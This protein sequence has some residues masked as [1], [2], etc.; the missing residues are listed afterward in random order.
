MCLEKKRKLVKSNRNIK[1]RWEL[2]VQLTKGIPDSQE[3]L[4]WNPLLK[5]TIFAKTRR[6]FIIHI[7][8]FSK[9][10]RGVHGVHGSASLM[11]ANLENQRKSGPDLSKLRTATI[12]TNVQYRNDQR[13]PRWMFGSGFTRLADPGFQTRNTPS[14]WKSVKLKHWRIC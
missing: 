14:M 2:R 12:P 8:P 6:N 13:C 9:F 11:G 3:N 4:V 10:P 5:C 1:L 7:A